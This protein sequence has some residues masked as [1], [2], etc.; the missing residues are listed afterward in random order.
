MG[1]IASRDFGLTNRDLLPRFFSTLFSGTVAL[2]RLETV[3]IFVIFVMGLTE[4]WSL[5]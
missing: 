2:L 1:V 4:L 3:P 5:S